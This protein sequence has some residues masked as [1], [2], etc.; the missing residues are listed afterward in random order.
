MKVRCFGCDIEKDT[1]V[2][3]VS[4]TADEDGLDG[5]PTEPFF[6]ISP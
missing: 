4:P 1:D 6:V 5:A 2:L 3:E